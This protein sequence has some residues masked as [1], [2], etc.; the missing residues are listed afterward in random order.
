MTA[1]R[2]VL[3]WSADSGRVPLRR[4]PTHRALRV[5][6]GDR[7]TPSVVTGRAGCLLDA[8]V[9]RDLADRPVIIERGGG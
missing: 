9:F 1:T 3:G 8:H 5:R 2:L 6:A 7:R 4:E